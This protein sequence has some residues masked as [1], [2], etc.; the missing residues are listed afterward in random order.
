[1]GG[2][3][4]QLV[5]Y[6]AQDV[7]LTG[8]PQ[9]TFFKVVYRRHTNFSVE[10][11][12]Q[13]FG[14]S[15]GDG[16]TLTCNLARNGDLIT[17]IYYVV[18]GTAGA[19]KTCAHWIS[20]VKIEI[21]GTKIDEHTGQWMDVWHNLTKNA[22][23]DTGYNEMTDGSGGTE[24]AHSDAESY[25]PLQF[26]FN[27]NPGLALPLIALQYHDVRITVETGTSGV[28]PTD[29][30]LLVDY[31]YL[32]SE[33]RKRFAQASHEY[34]IEQVQDSGAETIAASSTK[35]RLNFNHP[36]KF[37]AVVPTS[38]ELTEIK[39]SLNGHERMTERKPRYWMETQTLEHFSNSPASISS[40]GS[41]LY[42]YVYSFALNPEEHQ[43]SGTCNFSRI[44]NAT[45]TLTSDTADTTTNIYTMNYNVLRIMSGMGGLAY[46]N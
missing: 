38:N 42:S 17:N 18:R 39:L 31:V 40:G 16:K 9:I 24:G 4:M 32:D 11:V 44:D 5:A 19:S 7:Y 29:A 20:K 22:G 13:V 21:G 43:P 45:L 23:H 34:L 12:E 37:V 25:I 6:G 1:M 27:R 8:Q 26:W 14:G 41:T 15:V 28:T 35:V 33:E 36:C 10:P 30:K 2:G 3:L 46:S